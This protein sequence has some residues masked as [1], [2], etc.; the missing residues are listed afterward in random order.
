MK[1]PRSSY[2][3]IIQRHAGKSRSI[4]SRAL[5]RTKAPVVHAAVACDWAQS[6]TGD[7]VS[8]L[9]ERRRAYGLE[10]LPRLPRR[11]AP[12]QPQIASSY[13]RWARQRKKSG[14]LCWARAGELRTLT[15]SRK[16]G[17]ALRLLAARPPD[18]N[19]QRRPWPKVARRIR[20][21][22]E[23]Q[24]LCAD[25]NHRGPE[26]ILRGQRRRAT[27]NSQSTVGDH[28]SNAPSGPNQFRVASAVL[29]RRQRG[30]GRID[31]SLGWK[32]RKQV[33]AGKR[34]T[35]ALG[36]NCRGSRPANLC[37]AHWSTSC[38]CRYSGPPVAL[39]HPVAWRDRPSSPRSVWGGYA[40]RRRQPAPV[41]RWDLQRPAREKERAWY[42][43]SPTSDGTRESARG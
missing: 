23:V 16:R 36:K 34:S 39:R 2:L 27:S 29:M 26:C 6:F 35:I 31:V 8:G 43:A 7:D 15:L 40:A 41:P 32:A 28:R 13:P 4:T 22:A 10:T 17:R 42:R 25:G 18:V 20:R 12:L 9:V 37:R 33:D 24:S 14:L 19:F 11:H 30:G 21:T 38:R 3:R 5:T 1:Q